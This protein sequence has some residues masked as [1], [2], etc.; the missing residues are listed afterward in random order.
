MT[1]TAQELL[2]HVASDH[3]RGCQ[4]RQYTCD[5][6]YDMET[7]RLL[8]AAAKRIKE[9]EQEVDSLKGDLSA[10]NSMVRTKKHG[11]GATP[12]PMAYY[13]HEKG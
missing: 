6:R 12:W 10:Y 1:V 2:D 4:S 8:E 7:E 11:K 5:C 13:G 3:K 9:L